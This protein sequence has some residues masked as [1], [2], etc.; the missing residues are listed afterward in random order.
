MKR[1]K[2]WSDINASSALE[3]AILAPVFLS[4][5][6]VIFEGAQMIWTQQVLTEVASNTARCAGL[7]LSSCTGASTPA[8]YAVGRAADDGIAIATSEVAVNT[9]QTCQGISGMTMVTITHP[10]S[11][12]V[13][14]FVPTAP[15]QLVASACFS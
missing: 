3:F 12:V 9:N 8:S 1:R 13:T 6:L 10:Y 7:G 4:F 15:S 5:I 2:F 11:F 14:M